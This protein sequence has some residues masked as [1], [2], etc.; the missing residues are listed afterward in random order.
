MY[1]TEIRYN[2]KRNSVSRTRTVRRRRSVTHLLVMLLV[3]ALCFTAAVPG[4]GGTDVSAASAQASGKV[5]APGGAC[6]RAHTTT[7]SKQLM[8][9]SDDTGVTILREVFASKST[10]A[11]SR[12][13]YVS[14]NGK[15]GYIR[16]DLVDSISYANIPATATARANYRTGPTAGMKRKG[17]VS[18]G[19]SLTILS[20]AKL[21][22]NSQKWYRAAINGG[23]YYI[24][25]KYVKFGS[26]TASAAAT[27]TTAAAS[28]NNTAAAPAVS[29]Q[30]ANAILSK[31][32]VTGQRN[33]SFLEVGGRFTVKGVVNSPEPFDS[34]TV[35]VI[36]ASGQWA[37]SQTASVNAKKFDIYSIDNA[38]PFG[39]LPAGKY[40]YRVDVTFGGQTATKVSA[41][42]EVSSDKL[43]AGLLSNPTNGGSARYAY[44]FDSSNCRKLFEITGFSKALV[45]QAM[46]FTG[47]EYYILYGMNP[48]QAI[49]TYS[50]NGQKTK[51]GGFAFNIGHPNGI[52]WD[53]QTGLCY[54]FKGGQTTIYTWN[55]RT[56][57]YGKSKTPYSSSGLAYDK[58][59]NV[60]YAS[61]ETGIRIYTA[62]GRFQHQK[63][64]SRCRHSGKTHVQ[65]C[66]AQ[67][68]FIFH[69]VS[70]ANKHKTN[71]LDVYRASDCKYLGSIRIALGEIESAVVGN[72]GYLQLLVNTPQRTDY[73]WKTPLNINDLKK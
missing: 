60:I 2:A 19:Q 11:S 72:D 65:D 68:G 44:T 43:V 14:V 26:G 49:V 8:L 10:K 32:T 18:K 38:L 21:K 24:R 5:N 28:T 27:S 23:T 50:A 35:G 57:K 17:S 58:T 42:F 33:P 53:P 9:V 40:T 3:M 45:P 48:M 70:G 25:D 56:N 46:T 15:K 41:P 4:L 54:I 63:L 39:T 51:S 62:D 52:T 6:L 16:S 34:V 67:D 12:W 29:S 20:E 73:I 69:G 61:S 22:G 66:G 7:S 64:F 55:P 37:F 1:T 36:N 47:S 30:A 13:Y 59:T 71:Y 31:I